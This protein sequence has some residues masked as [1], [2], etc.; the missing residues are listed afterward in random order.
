MPITP[1]QLIDE[2]KKLRNEA[3]KL[4]SKANELDKKAIDLEAA[5]KEAKKELDRNKT[6]IF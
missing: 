1:Q 6:S 3:A 2:A 5:E 4:N